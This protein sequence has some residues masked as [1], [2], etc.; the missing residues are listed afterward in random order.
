MSSS[1]R[2]PERLREMYGAFR[3]DP[4]FAAKVQRALLGQKLGKVNQT[5]PDNQWPEPQTLGTDLPA[6]F[7]FRDE[8]LPEA[9][10]PWV[11]DIA[12]RMRVPQDVPAACT[13]ASLGGSVNRRAMIQPKA[14]DPN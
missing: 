8:F 7:P 4:D 9:V 6:V 3:R 5:R 1:P 11:R 12:E 14:A 2:Q 13:I 10:R